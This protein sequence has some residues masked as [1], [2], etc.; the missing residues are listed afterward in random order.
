MNVKEIIPLKWY[1][2]RYGDLFYIR[3]QQSDSSKFRYHGR[4]TKSSTAPESGIAT[5]PEW[6]ESAVLATEEKDFKKNIKV[7][8]DPFIEK[9]DYLIY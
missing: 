3:E 6:S 5:N 8:L 7:G 9:I 2:N 1:K 4:L